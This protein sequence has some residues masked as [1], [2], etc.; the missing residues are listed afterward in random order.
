MCVWLIAITFL[1]TFWSRKFDTQF[2]LKYTG[3]YEYVTI[4][5]SVTLALA[6]FSSLWY[7][8]FTYNKVTHHKWAAGMRK[9][10]GKFKARPFETLIRTRSNFILVK[11][12]YPYGLWVLLLL[13]LLLLCFFFIF[14]F[15][16]LALLWLCVFYRGRR[17]NHANHS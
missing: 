5:K 11:P 16:Y 3:Y 17:M 15:I 13:L 7:G 14:I 4:Y 2:G 10:H 9:F 1:F 6:L 12:A 8:C